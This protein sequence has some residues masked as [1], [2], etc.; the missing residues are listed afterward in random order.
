MV[1]EDV[2][3][4]VEVEVEVEV[5]VAKVSSRYLHVGVDPEVAV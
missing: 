5:V 4:E 3:V 2:V 1:D